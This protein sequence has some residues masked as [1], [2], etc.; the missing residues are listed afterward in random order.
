MTAGRLRHRV[1]VQ[2]PPGEGGRDPY[3]GAVRA[4]WTDVA[5]IWAE[6]RPL[7]GKEAAVVGQQVA[8]SVT[9]RVTVRHADGRAI[10]PRHQLLFEG[11]I[12]NVNAVIDVGERKRE[13]RILATE[14]T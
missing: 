14:A 9:H 4:D 8:A 2:A 10:T 1:T 12:L 13:L 7:T 11:R 5:T 6:V 3:G